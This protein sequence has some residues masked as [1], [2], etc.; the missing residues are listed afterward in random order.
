MA[1]KVLGPIGVIGSA[2][3]LETAATAWTTLA[4]CSLISRAGQTRAKSGSRIWRRDRIDTW[5]PR[6]RS[7]LNPMISHD[8]TKVAYTVPEGGRRFRL[9]SSRLRRH[10]EEGLRRLYVSGWFADNRRILAL[11]ARSGVLREVFA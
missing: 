2:P 5:S 4:A 3:E 9:S 11:N 7:Q 6:L 8:G 10:G 1:D